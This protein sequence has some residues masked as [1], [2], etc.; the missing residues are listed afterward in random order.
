MVLLLFLFSANGDALGQ[1]KLEDASA[2]QGVWEIKSA[3]TPEGDTLQGGAQMR[4]EGGI[5][6]IVWSTSKGT[7]SG[8]GL[9]VDG[10][11]YVGRSHSAGYGIAVYRSSRAGLEGIW[12]FAGGTSFGTERGRGGSLEKAKS[13]FEVVGTNPDGT[14]YVGELILT[15]LSKENGIF[16]VIW[17]I[18]DDRFEGIALHRG[19]ILAVGWGVGEIVEVIDY[20]ISNDSAI[21]P[22]AT[23]GQSSAGTEHLVRM[24]QPN[25]VGPG[26]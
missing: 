5:V 2:L 23:T 17:N 19:N 21:G 7:N 11:L 10:H 20:T 22:T 1:M 12:T 9:L 16:S 14:P 26:K 3:V 24:Q 18:G 6:G 15:R 13:R 25:S 8:V 4:P